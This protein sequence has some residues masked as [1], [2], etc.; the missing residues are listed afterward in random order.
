MTAG[1]LATGELRWAEICETVR[2]KAGDEHADD[3]FNADV[4]YVVPLYQRPY[5]WTQE[6]HWEPLSRVLLIEH[7]CAEEV[8]DRLAFV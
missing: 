1:T 2:D 8:P 6:R 5:L 4:R 3:I 7:D